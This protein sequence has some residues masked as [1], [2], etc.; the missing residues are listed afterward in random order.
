MSGFADRALLASFAHYISNQTGLQFLEERLSDLARGIEQA[1]PEFGFNDPEACAR[2]LMRGALSDE[3]MDVLAHHLTVGETYFFRDP[4]IF[5][6]L[7]R[8]ILPK[9]IT[10]R[11]KSG[12]TLRIWS[13]GCCSGEEAYSIAICV[14]RAVPDLADWDVLIVGTD[15]NPA[16][17][18]KA[19]QG[20]YG[21]W[22][23]RGTDPDLRKLYFTHTADGKW[24]IRPDIRKMV[25]FQN[26]NLASGTLPA[27]LGDG[28]LDLVFCRNVLIYFTSENALKVLDSICDSLSDGGWIAMGATDA[29][30]L[31]LQYKG[32]VKYKSSQVLRKMAVAG[33]AKFPESPVG[34]EE[35]GKQT[36]QPIVSNAVFFPVE[37]LP[38]KADVADFK[39]ANGPTQRVQA[40]GPAAGTVD[41]KDEHDA[42]LHARELADQKRLDDA[43]RQCE[44]AILSDKMNAHAHYL[45]GTILQEMSRPLDA[46]EA[47]RRAL[48]LDHDLILA[49]FA[50]GNIARAQNNLSE[51]D[52]HYRNALRAAKLLRPSSVVAESEGMTVAE[53]IEI[54]ISIR[55]KVSV[56]GP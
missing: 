56:I 3:Q 37:E 7:E 12:K 9:L 54:L 38:R 15:I 30:G 21:D 24:K 23:F 47:Y 18:R 48:Y 10:A 55:S 45:R 14:K 46:A 22:S 52:K 13:A 36:W 8:E 34:A 2:W 44:L 49:H 35:S 6:V 27:P 42:L 17:L 28:G 40:T 20:T 11:R 41:S 16:F 1:A 31:P 26:H 5:Q 51:A 25:Q 32:V 19:S 29:I 50:L 33:E 4:Q 39:N 53:I 43:L